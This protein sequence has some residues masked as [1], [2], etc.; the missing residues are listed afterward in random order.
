MKS[1]GLFAA[2]G[3]L[4]RAAPAARILKDFWR[5]RDITHA[6]PHDL[7]SHASLLNLIAT[8]K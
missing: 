5:G 1:L 3:R 7:S 8:K 4:G 6:R 2:L